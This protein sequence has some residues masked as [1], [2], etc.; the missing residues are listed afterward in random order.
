MPVRPGN[1]AERPRRISFHFIKNSVKYIQ[2]SVTSVL[3]ITQLTNFR[4]VF[5]ELRRVWFELRV[6]TVLFHTD[7]NYIQI[8]LTALYTG[9]WNFKITFHVYRAFGTHERVYH[10]YIAVGLLLYSRI[11]A[12]CW[13]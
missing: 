2:V 11:N 10:Q 3:K 9:G 13:W 6:K 7:K 4:T 1:N 5:R 12:V 8:R